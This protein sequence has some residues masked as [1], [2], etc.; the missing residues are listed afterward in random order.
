[1]NKIDAEESKQVDEG[2]YEAEYAGEF[3]KGQDVKRGGV[4][5]LV[6]P[7][8]EQEIGHREKKGEENAV[9]QI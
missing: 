7:P 3:G 9:S 4:T 6:A 1:M 5:D 8:V 2:G